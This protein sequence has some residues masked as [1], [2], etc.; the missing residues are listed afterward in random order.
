M[1]AKSNAYEVYYGSVVAKDKALR[2]KASKSEK[3]AGKG[4]GSASKTEGEA[5]STG[6][7][8]YSTTKKKERD[9]SGERKRSCDDSLGECTNYDPSACELFGSCQ[10]INNNE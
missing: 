9:G 3:T 7:S 1:I 4:K 8:K 2:D 6:I 5:A 10:C